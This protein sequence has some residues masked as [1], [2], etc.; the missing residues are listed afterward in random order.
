MWRVTATDDRD[1]EDRD[2][3]DQHTPERKNMNKGY[4]PSAKRQAEREHQA[5]QDAVNYAR[6]SVE[7]EGFKISAGCEARVQR[8]INNEISLAEFVNMPDNA[9]QGLA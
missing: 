5:R 8:Y 4:V 7:L 2:S 6:A 1:V 9:N 3:S